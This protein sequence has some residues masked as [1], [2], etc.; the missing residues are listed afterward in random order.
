MSAKEK[1][2][3]DFEWRDPVLL[4]SPAC[5]TVSLFHSLFQRAVRLEEGERML[6]LNFGENGAN[7]LELYAAY[8]AY[9][10]AMALLLAESEEETAAQPNNEGDDEALALQLHRRGDD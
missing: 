6:V 1:R 8:Q 10:E 3:V 4:C 2:L 7:S 5:A 9:Q